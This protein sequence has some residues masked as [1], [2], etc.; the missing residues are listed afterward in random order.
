MKVYEV[1]PRCKTCPHKTRCKRIRTLR[2]GIGKQKG[3]LKVCILSG[4]GKRGGT[5]TITA[6]GVHRYKKLKKVA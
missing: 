2:V 4:K 6:Y 1:K 3:Y 5:T